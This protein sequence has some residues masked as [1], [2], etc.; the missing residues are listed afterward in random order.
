MG[1]N[2]ITHRPGSGIPPAPGAYDIKQ[3]K[4]GPIWVQRPTQGARFRAQQRRH[5]L[6]YG[7]ALLLAVIVGLGS[8]IQHSAVAIVLLMLASA[9]II[10][11]GIKRWPQPP[12]NPGMPLFD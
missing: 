10:V 1:K 2:Q 9:F 7:A 4:Y 3:D 6:C 5:A 8:M 11:S 12:H